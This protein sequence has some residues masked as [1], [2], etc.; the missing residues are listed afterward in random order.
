M[1]VG[2]D[3]AG[4]HDHPPGVQ[5]PGP[6]RAESRRVEARTDRGD[7]PAG[8]QDVAVRDVP[9]RRIHGHHV[10]GPDDQIPAHRSSSGVRAVRKT[11]PH[12]PPGQA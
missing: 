3:Q 8:H 6:G 11:R 1:P 2:L 7:A 9:Q 12:R 10:T 5:L 4:R